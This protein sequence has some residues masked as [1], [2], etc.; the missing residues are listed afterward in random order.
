MSKVNKEL[1]IEYLKDIVNDVDNDKVEATQ[2]QRIGLFLMEYK[3]NMSLDEN[4]DITEK[5]LMRFLLTGW[6][7]YTIVL[8]TKTKTKTDESSGCESGTYGDDEME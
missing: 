8:K 2:L 3:F 4:E 1:M 5:D 7:I 6:Y